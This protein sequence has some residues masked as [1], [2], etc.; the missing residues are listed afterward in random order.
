MSLIH[1]EYICVY[2]GR[3]SVNCLLL[4]I[5][6]WIPVVPTPFDEK[7]IFL[8]L[9]SVNLFVLNQLIIDIRVWRLLRLKISI[10]EKR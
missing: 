10:K 7:S 5:C 4:F 1:S 2:S 9:N 3:Q 8:P 6:T